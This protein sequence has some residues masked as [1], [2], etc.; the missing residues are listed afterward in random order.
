MPS[1]AVIE[2]NDSDAD[3]NEIFA[4]QVMQNALLSRIGSGIDPVNGTQLQSLGLLKGA[5]PPAF[6]SEVLA[7]IE[8]PAHHSR[9]G[10]AEGPLIFV[11]F[12]ESVSIIEAH[13]ILLHP[14]RNVR[15]A[16]VSNLKSAANASPPWLSPYVQSILLEQAAR[17]ESTDATEWRQ[18]GIALIPVV[19]NDYA[20]MLGALRQSLRARYEEGIKE[21]LTRVLSPTWETLCQLSPGLLNPEEQPDEINKRL[22]EIAKRPSLWDA[23]SEYVDWCGHLP[24]QGDWSA[25]RLVEAWC[26]NH[27]NATPT[28]EELWTWADQRAVPVAIYHAVEIAL[29][30][31]PV[32]PTNDDRTIQEILRIVGVG[33]TEISAKPQATTWDMYCGLST[34]LLQLLEAAHPGQDGVRAAAY[35]WWLASQVMSVLGPERVRIDTVM[36][37]GLIPQTRLSHFRWTISRSLMLPAS[38]RYL[39]LF[40]GSVW[41]MSLVRLFV[42]QQCSANVNRIREKLPATFS[43]AVRDYL[44]TTPLANSFSKGGPFAFQLNADTFELDEQMGAPDSTSPSEAIRSIVNIRQN[45]ADQTSLREQLDHLTELEPDVRYFG[46]QLLKE[47]IFSTSTFD[48]VIETWLA[49]GAEVVRVLQELDEKDSLLLFE[50]LTEFHQRRSS[51]WAARLPHLLAWGIEQT[52]DVQRALLLFGGVLQMSINSGVTSPMQRAV[53]SKHREKLIEMLLSWRENLVFIAPRSEP[54]VA[55]R[56]RGMCATISRVAGPREYPTT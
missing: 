7:A 9:V 43:D 29:S 20:R 44:V 51:D 49:D 50:I 40:A 36:K 42:S 30:S 31:A 14:D 39:T 54:W 17:I 10:P 11:R 15:A 24:L 35:A 4:R 22:A 16:A 18:A 26:A 53:A 6:S 25:S 1:T 37:H 48:S 28:G 38:L 47:A 3:A 56:I 55:G 8:N 13:S 23:L 5:T 21:Y 2:Q 46:L 19:R 32:A 33:T 34:H 45:A 12:P 52:D 27:P 41:A